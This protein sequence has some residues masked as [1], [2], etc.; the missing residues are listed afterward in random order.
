[1]LL[2][3]LSCYKNTILMGPPPGSATHQEEALFFVWGAIPEHEVD[4]DAICPEGVSSIYEEQDYGDG[5]LA[6]VTLGFVKRVTITVTCADG[7]AWNLVPEPALEGTWAIPVE[8][9]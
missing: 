2:L 5:A 4:L 1:V 9:S 6:C 7:A 8:E 3:L